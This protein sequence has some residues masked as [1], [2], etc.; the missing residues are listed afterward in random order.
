MPERRP[1][2]GCVAT[3]YP[4]LKSVERH[5]VQAQLGLDIG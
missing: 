1:S 4:R 5:L 3:R 2:G